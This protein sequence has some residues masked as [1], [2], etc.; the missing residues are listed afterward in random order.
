MR[1]VAALTTF[2]KSPLR[3]VHMLGHQ[4]HLT[5]DSISDTTNGFGIY[6]V[7]PG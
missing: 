7:T 1:H 6:L 3:A 2:L 4:E 5:T